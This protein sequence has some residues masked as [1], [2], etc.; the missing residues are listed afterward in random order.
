MFHTVLHHR[1]KMVE[2][3]KMVGVEFDAAD[4][5]D[6]DDVERV[7][8]KY[9]FYDSFPEEDLEVLRK[10]LLPLGL[11]REVSEIA[12]LVETQLTLPWPPEMEREYV[13]EGDLE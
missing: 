1:S 2:W 7:L 11:S 9:G 10:E 13:V 8:W 5:V 6:V 12:R 3:I 4:L